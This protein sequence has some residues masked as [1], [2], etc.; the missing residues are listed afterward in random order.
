MCVYFFLLVHIHKLVEIT[1]DSI[2]QTLVTSQTIQNVP[3]PT[4][5]LPNDLPQ[6]KNTDL[7]DDVVKTALDIAREMRELP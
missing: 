6:S 5:Q 3:H 4:S 7:G 2:T 1:V